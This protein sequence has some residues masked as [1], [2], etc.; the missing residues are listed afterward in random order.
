MTR[1]LRCRLGLHCW[2]YFQH[3][4]SGLWVWHCTRC[5]KVKPAKQPHCQ[6]YRDHGEA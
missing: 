4:T 1:P 5:G 2:S 3:L 6:G